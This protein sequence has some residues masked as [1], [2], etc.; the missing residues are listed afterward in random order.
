MGNFIRLAF[1][2]LFKYKILSYVVKSKM[3]ST[4]IESTYKFSM[5]IC[6]S[7]HVLQFNSEY[8]KTNLFPRIKSVKKHFS[9]V[10]LIT[11]QLSE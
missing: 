7:M 8:R 9:P 1:L 6:S 5:S 2:N 4:P 10:I 3:L 11:L